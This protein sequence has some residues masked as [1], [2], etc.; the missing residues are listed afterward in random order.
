MGN[1]C[2]MKETEKSKKDLIADIAALRRRI[3]NL[4]KLDNHHSKFEKE[5][6]TCAER[7]HILFDNA[8]DAIFVHAISK[9]QGFGVFIEA[10]ETACT[11]LGYSRDDLLKKN[12]LDILDSPDHETIK[13]CI[14][15]LLDTRHAILQGIFVTKEHKHVP[16]ELNCHVF[17]FERKT[18]VLSVARDVTERK[19]TEELKQRRQDELEQEVKERTEE[20]RK[21][22][23]RFRAIY[24][25]SLLC[26]YIHDFEGRFLDANDAVLDLIGYTRAELLDLNIASLL[27]DEQLN[28][29]YQ[30]IQTL[31]QSGKQENLNQFRLRKKDGGFAWVETEAVLL[32]KNNEPYAIQ[33]IARDISKRKAVEEQWKRSEEDKAMILESIMEHVIYHDLHHK[34]IWANDAAAHSLSMMSAQLVG[35][36]C[37]RLWQQR[38]T[39]CPGCPVQEAMRTG[40]AQ[41]AEMTTPDGRIWL[42]RGYAVRDDTGAII[43]GVE[44][45]F[46]ITVIRQAD[47]ALRES[48]EKYK[49][50]TEN[51]NVGIYR[52]TTGSK[53]QFIEANPA[54]VR[55][56]GYTSKQEFLEMNAADLYQNP[57]DREEFNKK[58]M[59][60][61]FVREE[62]L[63][64]K[65][66]DGSPFFG[67]V[68]AV[69][70]KDEH[71]D[72]LYY[73]G[74]VYDITERKK[75]EDQLQES[76]LKLKHVL[77][78]TV[79]ALAS[80]TEKRDPYTAG[81][82]HRVAQL[83]CAIAREMGLSEEEIEGIRVAAI[84][85]DIGKIYVAAE[86]L[87]KPV[88]LK[89]IEMALVKA[90]CQAGYEILKTVDFPWPVARM[91]LQHHEKLDGSGYPNGLKDDEIILGAKILAVADVVEAMMS[92]RPYRSA[93]SIEEALNEV[94][95]NRGTLYASAVV[96]ACERVLANG[97]TFK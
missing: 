13:D 14:Q 96:D 64:L 4:E 15:L 32:Y 20:L 76:Y 40:K 89:D 5:L 7:Y 6:I 67:S 41:I 80:T 27:D 33:G 2:T 87:N 71:G 26:V 28:I 66:K 61:G 48:E 46:D 30:T 74:I 1:T 77:N 36:Y 18:M 83:A 54:I 73:D 16:V 79:N 21:S 42:I 37:F 9:E 29:V 72:V 78:G 34:I 86:I 44:V 95:T 92:H 69:A 3:A 88:K 25:R 93:L 24:D 58:M 81:H 53:G 23:A 35:Q 84:V 43:G 22:E 11:M 49:T 19:Q 51:L 50:L 97:F 82:Q 17:E 12:P 63:H 57:R 56:F 38:S 65:K 62:E 45:T 60:F 47:E 94:K 68:S 55:M 39:P 75:A 10:N 8:N 85:H 91:V 31:Q 70:V 52:N 59:K 90:H